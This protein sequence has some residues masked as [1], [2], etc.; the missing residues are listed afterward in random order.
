MPY[1]KGMKQLWNHGNQ[2]PSSS[3]QTHIMHWPVGREGQKGESSELHSEEK[4]CNYLKIMLRYQRGDMQ[5][6]KLEGAVEETVFRDTLTC[7]WPWTVWAGVVVL[8]LDELVGRW[9][10]RCRSEEQVG[11]LVSFISS[12]MT[13]VT[14]H[15][16]HMSDIVVALPVAKAKPSALVL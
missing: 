15:T 2:L 11:P 9:Q 7:V 6:I 3:A 14:L 4:V 1:K 13:P 12:G 5:E 10:R 16:L 8:T